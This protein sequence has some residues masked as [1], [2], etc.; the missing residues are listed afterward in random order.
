MCVVWYVYICTAYV[1]Y[2]LHNNIHATRIISDFIFI[3]I[4]C[5]C[6]RYM[7]RAQGGQKRVAAS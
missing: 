3:V 7:C 2:V 5:V 1:L 4:V 6:V